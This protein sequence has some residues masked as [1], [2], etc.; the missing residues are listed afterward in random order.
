MREVELAFTG[1]CRFAEERPRLRPLPERLFEARR[2]ELV[3]VSR[4]STVRLEGATYS[5]PSQWA[6]LRAT[7]HIGVEDVRLHCCGQSETYPK[8][9]KGSEKIRYRHYLSELS[10]KPQAVRQV[11]PELVQELG[12]P[13]GKLWEML[14]ARYGAKEASRVLARIVGASVDHGEKPVA[15]ALEAALSSGRCDLLSLAEHLHDKKQRTCVVEV[16]KALS[17]YHIESAKASDYDRLL[18]GITGGGEA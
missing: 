18:L 14:V 8:E 16:P 3:S 9:R 11:A 2:M 12:E 6:S 4:R 10:R 1:E 5:V 7:A 13:Y 15:D 17:G